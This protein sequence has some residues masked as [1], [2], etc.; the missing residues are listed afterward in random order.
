MIRRQQVGPF[1]ETLL[2]GFRVSHAVV[3]SIL[4]GHEVPLPCELVQQL[5]RR[6]RSVGIS[7]GYLA[8]LNFI[9]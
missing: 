2:H 9:G 8:L 4:A 5:Y 6:L 1:V 3:D 7:H